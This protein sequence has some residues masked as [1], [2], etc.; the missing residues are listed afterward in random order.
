MDAETFKSALNDHKVSEQST[1]SARNAALTAREQIRDTVNR[2]DE[3]VQLAVAKAVG[4]N[5]ELHVTSVEVRVTKV[6]PQTPICE[7]KK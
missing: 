3:K 7:P 6:E 2:M 4:A 1:Q 5:V